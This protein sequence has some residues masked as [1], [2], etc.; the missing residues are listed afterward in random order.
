MTKL[1]SE[2]AFSSMFHKNMMPTMSMIMTAIKNVTISA[3]NKSN[4]SSMNVQMNMANRVRMSCIVASC[5][6][7]RYC[8]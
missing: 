7:V 5:Q 8:S 4:E 3:V 2:M 6:I 1:T